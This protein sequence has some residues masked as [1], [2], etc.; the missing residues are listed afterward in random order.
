MQWCF[1]PQQ[2]SVSTWKAMRGESLS[3]LC[4]YNKHCV[5]W[6]QRIEIWIRDGPR[7]DSMGNEDHWPIVGV[8]IPAS[9][10]TFH[11][12]IMW[13]QRRRRLWDWRQSDEVNLKLWSTV[14]KVTSAHLGVASRC[15][16]CHS[17]GL[18]KRSFHKKEWNHVYTKNH[19]IPYY[20]DV[21]LLQ[22]QDKKKHEKRAL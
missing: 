8:P 17:K 5:V 6:K 10:E 21:T 4:L 13:R 11:D 18:K 19:T 20:T 3:R 2:A 15:H 7:R 22:L 16:R 14:K 9:P 12:F 1:K